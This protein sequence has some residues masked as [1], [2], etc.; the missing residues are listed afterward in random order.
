MEER[1]A[2]PFYKNFDVPL[3]EQIVRMEGGTA[4]SEDLMTILKRND[5]SITDLLESP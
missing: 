3:D 1:L 4:Q 2:N 5:K